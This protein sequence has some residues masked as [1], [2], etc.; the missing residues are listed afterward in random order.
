MLAN[1]AG[2]KGECLFCGSGDIKISS[3]Y[4]TDYF[5]KNC[6]N[7]GLIFSLSLKENFKN[8]LVWDK[9]N[10]YFSNPVASSF[11][12]LHPSVVN[13]AKSYNIYR[14]NSE[15]ELSLCLALSRP[16]MISLGIKYPHDDISC[17]YRFRK[18]L[19]ET[20][21]WL[22]WREDLASIV[23][24]YFGSNESALIIKKMIK[25]RSVDLSSKFLRD[26]INWLNKFAKYTIPKSYFQGAALLTIKEF[27][28]LI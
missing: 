4:P 2:L 5:C 18:H 8:N 22:I 10:H 17:P 11:T 12:F 24:F 16:A 26:E 27:E 19:A 6:K 21:G 20:R 9:I 23:E 13:L 1:R 28:S 14:V 3:T 15:R 7:G 25:S